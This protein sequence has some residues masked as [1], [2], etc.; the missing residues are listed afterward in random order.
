[1]GCSGLNL[2]RRL[3]TVIGGRA[4]V[5]FRPKAT[6][7]GQGLSVRLCAQLLAG[8]G[9]DKLQIA[10]RDLVSPPETYNRTGVSVYSI[11]RLRRTDGGAAGRL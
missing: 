8:R 4:A 1:M 3:G 10:R 11:A 6:V 7:P 9:K 5:C 2:K